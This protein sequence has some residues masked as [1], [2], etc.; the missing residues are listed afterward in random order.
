MKKVLRLL[1]LLMCGAVLT[2]P[3]LVG[4]QTLYPY[5]SMAPTSS[6]PFYGPA[7]Q[8]P[9]QQ[10]YVQ[11]CIPSY[12]YSSCGGGYPPVV[13]PCWQGGATS[14]EQLYRCGLS[15]VY[16]KR[17]YDAIRVFQQFLSYYPQSSLA[18]NALYW[19]G[20]AYYAQKQYYQA[21]GYFQ[22][23]LTQYPRGNK[24]PDALL[25]IALSQISLKRY[26]E[27]CQMIGELLHRYPNSDPARKAYYWWDRCGG[28]YW[29]VPLYREYSYHS[30]QPLPS[31]SDAALPKNW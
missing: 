27:G 23:I 28:G 22:Q 5:P 8:Q 21:M 16:A 31:Y 19:T 7:Y 30:Y 9:Y 10:P 4:A 12:A 14:S 3:V 15:L 24:V 26:N 1:V 11:P 6:M 2:L 13:T 20:E 18:D 17:Y 25:K 29:D